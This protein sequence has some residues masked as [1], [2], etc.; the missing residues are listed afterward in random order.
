MHDGRVR[1]N[2][3]RVIAIFQIDIW[4]AENGEILH[5][6]LVLNILRNV[7]LLHYRIESLHFL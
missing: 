4:N 6:N 2:D 5:V 3:E 7:Y 1:S